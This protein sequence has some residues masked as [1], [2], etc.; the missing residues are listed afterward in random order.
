VCDRNLINEEG[1]ARVVPL[2]HREEEQK[3]YIWFVDSG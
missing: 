3:N 2:H 1:I